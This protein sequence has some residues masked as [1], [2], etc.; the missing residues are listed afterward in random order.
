MPGG[1]GEALESLFSME[2]LLMLT[3]GTIVGLL[4]GLIPGLGGL[5]GMAMFLPLTLAMSPQGAL[6]F[7]AGIT[8]PRFTGAI[9]SI[10]INIP[11]NST[12]A[13]TAFD[14]Y[15]MARKGQADRAL[16]IAA[17][18]SILGTIFGLLVLLA[19][20]PAVLSIL[21][22]VGPHEL[23]A[24][25]IMAVI[26]VAFSSS[27]DAGSF[28]K[29]IASGGVGLMI[30]FI[31]IATVSGT[32]RFNFGS[33]QYLYNGVALIALFIGVFAVAQVL[34]FTADE[35]IVATDLSIQVN[36]SG[37]GIRQGIGDTFRN[38]RV[39]LQ[40]STIGAVI[41]ILPGIGGTAANFLAYSS[42]KAT[43]KN[44][45]RFGKGTPEGIVAPESSSNSDMV[46][47]IVP[48]VSFGI[49]GGAEGVLI[50]GLLTLHG[51]VTGPLLVRQH[52]E[53]LWILVAGA[54][55]AALATSVLC[56]MGVRWLAKVA[57]VPLTYMVPVILVAC[58][59]GVYADRQNLLDV[60]LAVAI[61][62]A[63]YFVIKAGFSAASLVIGYVLA[64]IMEDSFV[65]GWQSAD[66]DVLSFFASPL[67]I[68]LWLS[69]VALVVWS[70]FSTRR[71]NRQAKLAAD[72]SEP[73]V[74]SVAKPAKPAKRVKTAELVV[75][76][77]LTLFT[78]TLVLEA[79]G[80]PPLVRLVP[81]VVGVPTLA[82][83]L[84]V[85]LT[86]ARTRVKTRARVP[87][88]VAV[89][90]GAGMVHDG[91]GADDMHGADIEAA[92]AATPRTPSAARKRLV[93]GLVWLAA[94]TVLITAIGF[95]SASVLAVLAYVGYDLI[96]EHKQLS[97]RQV[98]L[99][100]VGAAVGVG[101]LLLAA[102][103]IDLAMFDGIV[104]GDR[105]PP[106]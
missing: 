83:L 4:S 98:V 52:P 70:V 39:V 68:V 64:P 105:L 40:G 18:S 25:A 48:T 97:R 10:L 33:D 67:S 94:Y 22:A 73:G 23:F 71:Q 51:F 86:Q 5:T 34:R 31:G 100:A 38:W 29:G 19:V 61:G 60:I 96:T 80:L 102:Q 74:V 90:V 28:A 81:L 37:S 99:R 16:S 44:P 54:V 12:N 53:V 49:P 15:P 95:I 101:V 14:G 42:A 41:G 13:A 91:A 6:L 20:M 46:S 11:G 35:R 47:S 77:L 85:L 36:S 88:N 84:V 27:T 93:A 78:A 75:T 55:L 2:G 76:G 3:L 63:A 56:L 57:L 89:G 103:S 79:F 87:E 17:T 32:P 59:Y 50:L 104:F 8:G 24:L 30:G 7:F 58:L 45:Q 82:L 69:T 62:I 72:P 21:K 9:T 1:F 106:V 66:R 65:L 26:M 92:P 43:S